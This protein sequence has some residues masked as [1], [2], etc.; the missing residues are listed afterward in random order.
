MSVNLTMKYPA[1]VRSRD[2]NTTRQQQNINLDNAKAM[3]GTESY[4]PAKPYQGCTLCDKA[5]SAGT[6]CCEK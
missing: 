5:S 1:S 2:F 3:N 4:A 6:T